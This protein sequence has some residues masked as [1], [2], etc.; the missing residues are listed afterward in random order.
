MR[1]ISRQIGTNAFVE[2]VDVKSSIII[3]V[4]PEFF[5]VGISGGPAYVLLLLLQSDQ[6]NFQTGRCCVQ[7]TLTNVYFIPRP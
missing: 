1:Q 3:Y 5:D 6:S 4:G 2:A 7:P